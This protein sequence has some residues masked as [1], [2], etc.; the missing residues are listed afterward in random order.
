MAHSFSPVTSCANLSALARGGARGASCSDSGTPPA[1]RSWPASPKGLSEGGGSGGGSRAPAAAARPHHHVSFLQP[2]ELTCH[3]HTRL[4]GAPVGAAGDCSSGGD[5][6][7]EGTGRGASSGDEAPA[8]ARRARSVCIAALK[9]VPTDGE[10]VRAMGPRRAA[11]G[12]LAQK[13]RARSGNPA[14]L[15]H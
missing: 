11:R 10:E 2:E 13:G 9:D 7:G 5:G 15:R 6:G 12:S 4:G 8:A 3:I 14:S 1:G